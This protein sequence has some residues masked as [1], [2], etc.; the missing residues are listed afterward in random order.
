MRNYINCNPIITDCDFIGNVAF[1]DGGGL[2]NRKNSNAIVTGCMFIGNT[3]GGS[4]GG[5]DNYVGKATSTG[6]PVI[7][8][9]LFINNDADVGGGMRNADPNPIVIN[10]TFSNNTGSGMA[11]IKGSVPIIS[12]CIF[13]ANTGGSF[14]GSSNPAVTF[15]DV[16]GGFPGTGNINAD[17][18]FVDASNPDPNL[19]DYH[20]LPGSPCIDAGDNNLV[21]ADTTDLDNDG[22]TT[23]PIPW[24]IDGDTRFDDGD[25]NGIAVVDMGSDEVM[26]WDGA[27]G[28]G[29]GGPVTL[30]PGG[31]VNDPSIEALVAFFIYWASNA[32]ITVVETAC[33]PHSPTDG[34][35]ALGTTLR[36]ETNLTDGEF[37]MTV[38]IPFDVNDLDGADPCTVDLMYYDTSNGV[39]TLAV[40]NNTGGTSMRWVEITSSDPE[41]LPLPTLAPLNSR[42]LGD[43]GVCWNMDTQAGFVW[44]NTW[45]I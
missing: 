29:P 2:N 17:P 44:A 39:W 20:L 19:R 32:N 16:E 25:N 36:I 4:G 7:I 11:N 33:D 12:N 30:N 14:N 23:E 8:N 43:Y 40:Q 31:G 37:L 24:D 5:M 1:E 6:E 18:L 34:F 13:W 21:P 26:I 22:N 27:S 45:T 28:I 41:H 15:S 3:A 35:V 38:A 42:P 9:C 10:C